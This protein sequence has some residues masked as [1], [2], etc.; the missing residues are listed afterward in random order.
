M[1]GSCDAVVKK[2]RRV[3]WTCMRISMESTNGVCMWGTHEGNIGLFWEIHDTC[4]ATKTLSSLRFGMCWNLN[5]VAGWCGVRNVAAAVE[6]KCVENQTCGDV[7][8]LRMQ[9]RLCGLVH[10][11]KIQHSFAGNSEFSVYPHNQHEFAVRWRVC[12]E[13][14]K[15]SSSSLEYRFVRNVVLFVTFPVSSGCLTKEY[16]FQYEHT[17]MSTETCRIFHPGPLR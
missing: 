12:V 11:S 14:T 6:R 7:G 9:S 15:S 10:C 3:R 13:V 16:G 1:A 4:V 8:Q 17:T 5:V 2:R